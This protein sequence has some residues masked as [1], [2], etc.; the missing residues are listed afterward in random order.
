[1]DS[2]GTAEI[3]EVGAVHLAREWLAGVD[4]RLQERH[5]ASVQ[6][7]ADS[8]R[9][10]GSSTAAID[11]DLVEP[12]VSDLL[13]GHAHDRLGDWHGDDGLARDARTMS[14]RPHRGRERKTGA[15][16]LPRGYTSRLR[17]PFCVKQ[18]IVRS[19][20]RLL[21]GWKRPPGRG[22]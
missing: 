6:H 10:I 13:D 9:P 22:R 7:R 1:V 16:T 3:A 2:R 21:C 5:D 14:P 12:C 20:S 4:D 11:V 15:E 8:V 18:F 17:L 19:A